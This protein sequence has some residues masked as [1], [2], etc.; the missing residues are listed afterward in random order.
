MIQ[1]MTTRGLVPG[2]H[3]QA[4]VSFVELQLPRVVQNVGGAQKGE[5]GGFINPIASMYGISTYIYHK[6]QQM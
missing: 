6:N 5:T 4:D 3:R 2:F 1:Y